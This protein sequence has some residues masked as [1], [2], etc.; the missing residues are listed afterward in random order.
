MNKYDVV[1]ALRH[2]FLTSAVDGVEWSAPSPL[3]SWQG[4]PVT[5]GQKAGWA[6]VF[7]AIVFRSYRVSYLHEV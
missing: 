6:L 5:K 4:P 7:Q 3:P 1:E 2:S